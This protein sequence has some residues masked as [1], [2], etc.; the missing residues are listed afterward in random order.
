MEKNV[1]G[2]D[3]TVRLV[4]GTALVL[5]ALRSSNRRDHEDH[6]TRGQLLAMY[7]GADLLVSGLVQW[8]PTT[9]VLGIN[10]CEPQ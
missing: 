2:L 8:C 3:R 6:V 10:T 7:A 1:C 4:V 5:V 9:Y